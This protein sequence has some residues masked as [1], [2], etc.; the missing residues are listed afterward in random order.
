M[1]NDVWKLENVS[2][3]SDLDS[4]L[5]FESWKMHQIKP[6]CLIKAITDWSVLPAKYTFPFLLA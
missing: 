6:V 3:P 5:L 4:S 1:K 2:I